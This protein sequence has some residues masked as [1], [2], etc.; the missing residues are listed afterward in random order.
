MSFKRNLSDVLL[1]LYCSFIVS[2]LKSDLGGL[3]LSKVLWD[4][5]CEERLYVINKSP[6]DSFVSLFSFL[7]CFHVQFPLG[8]VIFSKPLQINHRVSCKK[9]TI[10]FYSVFVSC[11]F[12]MWAVTLLVSFIQCVC[13]SQSSLWT[14]PREIAINPGVDDEYRNVLRSVEGAH[15]HLV[16]GVMLTHCGLTNLWMKACCTSVSALV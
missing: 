1:F 4:M 5:T 12:S 16:S 10:C 9:K 13:W 3:V 7:S 14:F 11:S 15:M 8:F 6:V 2:Q